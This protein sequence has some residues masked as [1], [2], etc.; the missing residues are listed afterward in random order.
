MKPI[1]LKTA[2]FCCLAGFVACTGEN[3]RRES[4]SFTRSDSVT[5]RYLALQDSMLNTWNAI[6]TDEN[7]K[8]KSMR[9]LLYALAESGLHD[10]SQL[11]V[12]ELRLNQLERIRFSQKTLSN[13]HV[14]EEYDFASNSLIFEIITL[15]ESDGS[16]PDNKN[17]QRWVD[18]VKIADQR[19]LFYRADYDSI[20]TVFNLFLDANRGYLDA[21]DND[22]SR[23]K[24][25]LF[26]VAEN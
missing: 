18:D 4:S 14:I 22:L 12:L 13:P 10:K 1:V 19:I 21:L 24:R 15:A 3:S 20:T 5:E 2:V 6:T 16:F 8:I 11:A 25:P 17:L 26:Q 9:E 23:E 7:R